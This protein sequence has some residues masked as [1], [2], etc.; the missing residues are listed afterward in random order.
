MED[1]EI[2]PLKE[3][4]RYPNRFKPGHTRSIGNSGGKVS[5]WTPERIEEER[6][7]LEDWMQNTDNYF[8]VGYLNQRRLLRETC[9]YICTRDQ[10]YAETV[11]LAKSLQEERLVNKAVN[12]KGDG[13]FIKF[14]LANKCGWKEQQDVNHSFNPMADILKRIEQ[15]HIDVTPEA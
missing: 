8:F 10:A 12:R 14:V 6:L 15:S 1:K 7:A 13:N 3:R 5:I 9:D 11:K 2:E 4:E